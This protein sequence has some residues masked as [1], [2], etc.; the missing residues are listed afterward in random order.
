MSR[1]E[2][3]CK[4]CLACFEVVP[5]ATARCPSCGTALTAREY[6]EAAGM[7]ALTAPGPPHHV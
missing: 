5:N 1:R 4:F 3:P 6:K 2:M 7:A